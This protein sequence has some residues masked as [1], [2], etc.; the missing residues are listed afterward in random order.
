MERPMKRFHLEL[1][2]LLAMAPLAACGEAYHV[3]NDGSTVVAVKGEEFKIAIRSAGD[4]GYSNW[5]LVASPSASI[6]LLVRSYHEA[7]ISG[8]AGDFGRDV[9]EFRAVGAGTTKASFS[10]ARSFSGES[11]REVITL[12]VK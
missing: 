4:G 3:V 6:V 1:L 8:L 10:A 7:P 11:Q 12:V 5:A 2:L 9:F